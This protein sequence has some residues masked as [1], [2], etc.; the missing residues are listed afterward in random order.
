[1]PQGTP[2]NSFSALRPIATRASRVTL[3]PAASRKARHEA[4]SMAA[5]LLRPAPVGT[6]E[7]AR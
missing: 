6:F 7:A 1:M 3:E 4:S 2:T 5:L